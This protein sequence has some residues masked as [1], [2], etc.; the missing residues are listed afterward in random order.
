MIGMPFGRWALNA[1][2]RFHLSASGPNRGSMT[3]K[4]TTKFIA[5]E[6]HTV[7]SSNE[8][9]SCLL[10]TLNAPSQQS[11]ERVR[12]TPTGVTVTV[13]ERIQA[14]EFCS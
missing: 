7:P 8:T 9:C 2:C 1:F 12:S 10:L 14:S 13:N 4:E 6:A 11:L 5:N 3:S